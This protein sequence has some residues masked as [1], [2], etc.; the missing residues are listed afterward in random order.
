[1]APKFIKLKHIERRYPG[2]NRQYT[3]EI[4]EKLG[5]AVAVNHIYELAPG[6]VGGN[7]RHD[8]LEAFV[9][10]GEGLVLYWLDQNNEVKSEPMYQLGQLKLCII[11]NNLAHAVCNKGNEPA[12]LLEYA[13]KAKSDWVQ[14]KII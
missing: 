8:K 6:A 1:M 12:F 14:Q 11:P 3:S 5:F 10:L 13:D 7:H 4:F 2:I 9:G